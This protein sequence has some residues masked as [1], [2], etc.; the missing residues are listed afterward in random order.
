[1]YRKPELEKE[2]WKILIK[3]GE[4]ENFHEMRKLS[5]QHL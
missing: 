4:L 2:F 5:K 1:M 3:Y